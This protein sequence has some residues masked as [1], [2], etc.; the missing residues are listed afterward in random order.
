MKPVDEELYLSTSGEKNYAI[1]IHLS[2]EVLSSFTC[3]LGED[4]NPEIMVNYQLFRDF[5]DFSLIRE[6][7]IVELKRFGNRDSLLLECAADDSIGAIGIEMAIPTLDRDDD[8]EARE[9][10]H[11]LIEGA[12]QPVD[13][14]L[15]TSG[16]AFRVFGSFL[17]ADSK[18][19]TIEY[20]HEVKKVKFIS[21]TDH[22]SSEFLLGEAAPDSWIE[23]RASGSYRYR[24]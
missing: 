8:D 16:S 23:I 13:L 6:S 9:G 14:K 21:E 19:V 3:T 5:L 17:N 10:Y 2:S 11:H 18:K 24:K 4:E 22:C 12:G 7:R 15:F 20:D 1:T